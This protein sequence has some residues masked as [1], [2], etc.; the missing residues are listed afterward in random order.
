[1]KPINR[2]DRAEFGAFVFN[3]LK[4]QGVDLILSGGSCVSIYTDED[5]ASGYLDFIQTSLVSRAKIEA[6]LLKNGFKK[7]NR[8]FKH[9]ETP[10][11]IEFPG[12]PPS[13]GEAPIID[14]I[15]IITDSGELHLLTPTDCVKDRLVDYF[16]WDDEESLE[17]A[18]MVAK[19][20]TIDIADIEEWSCIE[21]KLEI[22][23]KIQSFLES[24]IINS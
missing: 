23:K 9:P 11:F 3:L 7:E 6:T 4:H 15:T 18:I 5:Y 24:Q 13:I 22:F 16:H 8:Y 12:G 17:H 2:M 14:F 20:Q 19:C 21:G 1:M 10:F